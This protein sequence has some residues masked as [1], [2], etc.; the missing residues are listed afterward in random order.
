[1]GS[2]ASAFGGVASSLISAKS[3]SDANKEASKSVEGQIAFQREMS[4]TAHQRAM[5]DLR[6]AGLNPIL[7]ARSPASTPGGASYQPISAMTEGINTGL[8][9]YNTIT[10]G[11]QTQAQTSLTKQQEDKTN[12]E[13]IQI[14][15]QHH[16]TDAQTELAREKIKE[17]FENIQLLRAKEGWQRAI[18]AI[19]AMAADIT[20]AIREM[21]SVSNE[22]GMKSA[23][24]RL[25]KSLNQTGENLGKGAYNLMNPQPNQGGF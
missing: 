6:R 4:N 25:L 13:T 10:Q 22:S 14:A 17:T 24:E 20:R 23:F 9:A 18:T 7:A 8:Q 3:A 21:G 12:Q 16:L 19:P 11:Q 1:M 5:K 2:V 15:K